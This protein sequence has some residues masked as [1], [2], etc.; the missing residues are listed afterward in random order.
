MSRILI[1]A[2]LV[3]AF[4]L[5]LNTGVRADEAAEKYVDDALPLMYHSCASVVAEAAG[6]NAYIEKVI[7]ALAAVS[8]YN[9]NVEISAFE[10]SDEAKNALHDKFVAALKKGCEADKNALLAGVIDNAVAVALAGK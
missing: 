8:L 9:R 1:A 4:L 6:D 7:R 5:S 3:P 2:A 10:I